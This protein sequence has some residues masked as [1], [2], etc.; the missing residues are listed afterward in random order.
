MTRGASH[1]GVRLV[2]RKPGRVVIETRQL[3]ALSCSRMAARTLLL[4][5]L[6]ELTSV[7][8]CVAFVASTTHRTLI[9]ATVIGRLGKLDVTGVAL[10][11]SM[12][13][14]QFKASPI[15]VV[16]ATQRRGL[17]AARLMA[18]CT[19]LLTQHC[20]APRLLVEQTEVWVA[21]AGDAPGMFSRVMV[22][23]KAKVA[24]LLAGSV[25]SCTCGRRVRPVQFVTGPETVIKFGMQLIKCV[26]VVAAVAASPA[27]E[28][29]GYSRC[30]ECSGVHVGV[31]IH[32]SRRV[33][34]E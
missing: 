7:R 15:V 29:T 13:A 9:A 33:A 20:R 22:A 34:R 12:R 4:P 32:A 5:G 27:F 17:E 30:I 11:G 16:E 28:F 14:A 23:D 26:D 3:P 1:F 18:T 21:M 8:V 24:F 25:A 19:V 2:Q 6:S 31:A 10:R